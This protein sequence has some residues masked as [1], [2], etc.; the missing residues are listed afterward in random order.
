MSDSKPAEQLLREKQSTNRILRER[1]Q[2]RQLNGKQDTNHLLQER[3]AD[4]E[5][6]HQQFILHRKTCQES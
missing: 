6:S 3:K 4:H 2:A 5:H 1:R